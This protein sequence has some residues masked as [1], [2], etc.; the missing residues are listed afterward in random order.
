MAGTVGGTARRQRLTVEQ[1]RERHDA[2][3]AK[4]ADAVAGRR[5]ASREADDFV[6]FEALL[7]G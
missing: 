4:L 5:S 7:A 3:V 1:R 2:L 6:V